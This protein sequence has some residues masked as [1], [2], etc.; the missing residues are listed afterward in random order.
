MTSGGYHT[1]HEKAG[2]YYRWSLLEEILRRQKLEDT[3]A[4]KD[5][6]LLYD[7]LD[8]ELQSAT[9]LAARQ[10]THVGVEQIVTVLRATG[11][12]AGAKI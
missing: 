4:A 11:K 6:Q 1:I 9:L 7:V 5:T 8:N 10:D 3:D 12:A 2:F